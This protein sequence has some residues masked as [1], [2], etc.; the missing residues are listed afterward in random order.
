MFP[1]EANPHQVSQLIEGCHLLHV[2]CFVI[3]EPRSTG[4]ECR[5]KEP[6]PSAI[7]VLD[8]SKPVNRS[9]PGRPSARLFLS[10]PEQRFLD[11]W[12]HR[13][14]IG[15]Q[16]G[17]GLDGDGDRG[18]GHGLEPGLEFAPFS[19]PELSHREHTARQRDGLRSVGELIEWIVHHVAG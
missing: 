12:R 15:P 1:V 8:C 16:F 13:S 17:Q 6:G 19:K 11:I 7:H 9:D 5:L 10:L 3:A 14:P 4:R 18:R 2:G